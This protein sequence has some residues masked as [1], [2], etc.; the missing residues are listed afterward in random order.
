M[1][2]GRER[3]RGSRSQRG[4]GDRRAAELAVA[5]ERAQ[6][7]SLYHPAASRAPAEPSV[8]WP[9]SG[10]S[11]GGSGSNPAIA[12]YSKKGHISGTEPRKPAKPVNCARL[13]GQFSLAPARQ[14][15]PSPKVSN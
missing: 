10:I 13:A 9:L 1:S 3:Q 6:L 5:A 4:C 12:C 2:C 7:T 15:P 8:E 11:N 14:S